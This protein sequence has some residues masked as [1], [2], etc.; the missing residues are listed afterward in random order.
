[1]PI[2]PLACCREG[3]ETFVGIGPAHHPAASAF[4][5]AIGGQFVL[6]RLLVEVGE[7]VAEGDAIV[8]E[9]HDQT[10]GSVFIHIQIVQ[11]ILVGTI[12]AVPTLA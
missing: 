6:Q 3:K 12:E 2:L 8:V 10:H 7:F 5:N 1:M 4:R 9:P 11:H